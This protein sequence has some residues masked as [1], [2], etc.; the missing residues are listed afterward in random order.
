[1]PTKTSPKKIKQPTRAPE[2]GASASTLSDPLFDERQTAAKL[3]LKNHETLAVW[4]STKRYPLAFVRVGR[5]IRYRL[6]AIEAFLLS[7]T[8]NGDDERKRVS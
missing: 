6:S 4:R 7:R 2:A 5:L 3:G 8:V 1:M